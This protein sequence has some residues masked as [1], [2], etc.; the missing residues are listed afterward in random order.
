MKQLKE[1]MLLLIANDES[2]SEE[3]LDHASTGSIIG[4]VTSTVTSLC[5]LNVYILNRNSFLLYNL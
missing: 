4:G 3:W 2:T 5:A 1:V